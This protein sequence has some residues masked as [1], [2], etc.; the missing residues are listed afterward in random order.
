[1]FPLNIWVLEVVVGHAIMLVFNGY[2]VAWN[3]DDYADVMCNGCIRIGHGV[4]WLGLGAICYPLYPRMV[5]WTQGALSG[6]G[7]G[8]GG[9]G[10][11]GG[12]L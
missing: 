2:N 3:Y 4:W 12:G 10:G 9:G 6:G 11:A 7:G 5:E 8:G 1:L